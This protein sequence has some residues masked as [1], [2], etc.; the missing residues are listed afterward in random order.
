MILPQLPVRLHNHDLL[1]L[2]VLE[3]HEDKFVFQLQGTPDLGE[4]GLRVLAHSLPCLNMSLSD[5][6]LVR[7]VELLHQRRQVADPD[8][9]LEEIP[10]RAL[11]TRR[12]EGEA[13]AGVGCRPRVWT[14]N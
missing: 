7:G 5:F 14:T 1:L 11:G 3:L 9:V 2:Q 10:E 6:L 13:Q 4:L 8:L 12:K